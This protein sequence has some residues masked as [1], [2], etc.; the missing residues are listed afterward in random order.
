MIAQKWWK[1]QVLR[2]IT[3]MTNKYCHKVPESVAQANTGKIIEA[4]IAQQKNIPN[5]INRN[6]YKILI[7]Y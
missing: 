3:S 6:D 4:N 2:L 5:E 1:M 7:N